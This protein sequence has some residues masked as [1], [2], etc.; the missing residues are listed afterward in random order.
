MRN[1][2]LK[3]GSALFS[4]YMLIYMVVVIVSCSKVEEENEML[5]TKEKLIEICQLSET[6]YE[7]IDLDEFIKEYSLTERAL[8]KIDIQIFLEKY[9]KLKEQADINDK[10]D[11]FYQYL[12]EAE[13]ANAQ[14]VEGEIDDISVVALYIT[15][16]MEQESVIVDYS[17]EMIYYGENIN[18]LYDGV[19]PTYSVEL[20]EKKKNAI[21]NMWLECEI[22][23]WERKY[24]QWDENESETMG[25]ILYIELEDGK[26]KTYEGGYH[27]DITPSGYSIMKQALFQWNL[28]E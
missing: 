18:L 21:Q 16:G 11:I 13:K 3:I 9:R 10:G 4:V 7:N 26:I 6:E 24:E 22:F 27:G 23:S 17:K 15:R 28:K 1:R 20:D 8:E 5:I 19:N 25:W 12:R 2:L 14:I